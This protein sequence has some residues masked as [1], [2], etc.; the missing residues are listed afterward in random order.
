MCD[1]AHRYVGKIENQSTRD[2]HIHKQYTWAMNFIPHILNL[3]YGY[4]HIIVIE[5]GFSAT[6]FLE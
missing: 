6:Q 4:A 5:K 2:D 1:S 3:L